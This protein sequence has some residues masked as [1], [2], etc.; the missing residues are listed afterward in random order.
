[1]SPLQA[2]HTPALASYKWFHRIVKE[3]KN[4][5]LTFRSDGAIA[6]HLVR[7]ATPQRGSA[8]LAIC[9]TNERPLARVR[10]AL[11]VI[12]TV[13]T[14]GRRLARCQDALEKKRESTPLTPHRLCLQAEARWPVRRPHW[15]WGR[16]V[17][18]KDTGGRSR[19]SSEN[20]L[21]VSGYSAWPG[22]AS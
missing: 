1:V 22:R 5:H 4:V 16:L 10:F 8:F 7:G 17:S 11:V 12:R 2:S 15:R 19:S 21:A 13:L 18:K 14:I 3:L 9:E 6:S 20:R